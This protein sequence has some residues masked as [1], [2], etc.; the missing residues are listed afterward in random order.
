MINDPH[1]D[2][3]FAEKRENELE[4]HFDKKIQTNRERES[5]FVTNKSRARAEEANKALR[6][7]K[8]RKNHFDEVH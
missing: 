2:F 4:N 3:K 5:E 8:R 6:E 7:E 1:G